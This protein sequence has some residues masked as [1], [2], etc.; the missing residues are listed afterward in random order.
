MS[1]QMILRAVITEKSSDAHAANKYTF[2]IGPDANKIEIRQ[3]IE[4]KYNVDVL[5]V[6][7]VKLPGKKRRR[8]RIVGRTSAR[9]KAIV[10]LASGSKIDD[11]EELF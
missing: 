11:I 1:K 4:K 7:V 5:K 3:F 2:L 8:G 6:N 10:T 9:K